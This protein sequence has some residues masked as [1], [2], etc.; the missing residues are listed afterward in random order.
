MVSARD[1]TRVT[2]ATG[3]TGTT[4]AAAPRR[5]HT[6]MDTASRSRVACSHAAP[7]TR[8]HT[9]H[10]HVKKHARTPR[11]C[12]SKAQ[13]SLAGASH[14]MSVLL[15]SQQIVRWSLEQDSSRLWSWGHHDMPSTPWACPTAC[16]CVC[17]CVCACVCVCVCVC[18]QGVQS[19]ES[20]QQTAQRWSLATSW[21]L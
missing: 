5:G 1:D 15:T 12:T 19:N 13:V 10:L 8:A 11:T 6:S 4:G 7:Q 9:T 18:V 21:W 16:V 3:V 14:T 2:G 17:V 20:A